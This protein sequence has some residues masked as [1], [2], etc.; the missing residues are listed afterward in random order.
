MHDG[1]KIKRHKMVT[2]FSHIL[3]YEN[4]EYLLVTPVEKVRIQVEDAP[5]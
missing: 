2:L 1:Y 3:W 5:F 4:G